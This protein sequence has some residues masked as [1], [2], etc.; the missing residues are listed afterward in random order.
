MT[1]QSLLAKYVV[2]FLNTYNINIIKIG[3]RYLYQLDKN[4]EN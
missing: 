4:H 1:S 2:F 3:T